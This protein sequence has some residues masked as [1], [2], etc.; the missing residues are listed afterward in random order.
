MP[1]QGRNRR[2][3]LQERFGDADHFAAA[4]QQLTTLGAELGIDF[5]FAAIE[6]APNT[7]RAHLLLAAAR[8][9][10]VSVQ[11]ELKSRLFAA[12]FTE[13]LDIGDPIVLGTLA[14]QSGLDR[15]TA[16]QALLDPALRADV[17]QWMQLARRWRIGGVPSFIFDRRGTFS[18]AQPVEVF[19]RAIDFC[20]APVSS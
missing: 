14:E 10:S 19:L 8:R 5:R 18:G 6:R 2:E 13:G 15:E 17:E 9:I 16:V 12:Y 20:S 3:Y 7:L 11:N 4:Q 1:E